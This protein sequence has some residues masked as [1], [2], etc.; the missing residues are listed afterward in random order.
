[1]PDESRFDSGAFTLEDAP[2]GSG[3]SEH[4]FGRAPQNVNNAVT[5]QAIK[6][7]D[8]ETPKD[9]HQ[10][11]DLLEA[12]RKRRGEREAAG[13][14]DSQPQAIDVPLDP[15]DA[16]NAPVQPG[17]TGSHAAPQAGDRSGTGPVR[18]AKRGR[19]SMPSWDEIVFG[20]RT[21]DDLA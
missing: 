20:A 3:R 5:I 19:K 4:S 2:S 11:A 21:D 16:T 1:V 9:V 10:T 12:L 15:F 6:R 17:S 13:F 18:G 8:D 7:A 14:R